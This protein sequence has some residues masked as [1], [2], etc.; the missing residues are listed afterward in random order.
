[1]AS[2]HDSYLGMAEEITYGTAVA[3][4]RFLEMVKEGIK[5][6]YERIDSEAFRAGQ[7]VLHK[8]RFQPNPKGAEGDID[9][10]G[11]DSTL[12]MLFKHSMG[13]FSS[14][15]PVGGF[16]THTFTVGDLKGKSLTVQ[17]GRVDNTGTLYPFTYE[18]GKVASFELSNAVDGVLKAQFS[19]DFEKETIG[20]GAGAYAASTP[21]YTTTG[22]LFTFVGG[23]VDVGGAPFGVSDVSF[24]GDNQLKTDRWLSTGKREPLEEGMRE[25]EFELKGEFEGLA[26]ANRVAAAV[27]SGAIASVTLTWASPQGG[28][29]TVTM[30]ASRFDEG[31]VN[32]DGAKI[33][34]QG[35][36]G[37]V[38]WDGAASP[39][40]IAYKT[41]DATP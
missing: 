32:F 30:P 8:D 36:K 20:A 31:D 24:K 25:Y 5:G 15:A 6:K 17:V 12:G 4:V 9:L 11:M 18:G 2:I 7:R 22:Q 27:A 1:M 23:T 26:H 33:I 41:K 38:L 29:L 10:E 21:T 40:T 39:V 35:L 14:A 3:P 28:Q 34:E 37:I 19:L 16:T 13:A